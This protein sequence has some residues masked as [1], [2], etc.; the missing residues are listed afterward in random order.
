MWVLADHTSSCGAYFM[1]EFAYFIWFHKRVVNVGHAYQTEPINGRTSV[2]VHS[3]IWSNHPEPDMGRDQ[4]RAASL[5]INQTNKYKIMLLGCMWWCGGRRIGGCPFIIIITKNE[6][7][8]DSIESYN[9]HTLI[10]ENTHAQ[11]ILINYYYYYC[12]GR[13]RVCFVPSQVALICSTSGDDSPWS[14]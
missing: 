8:W 9:I 12:C 6:L 1:L 3:L 10:H 11:A 2:L 7:S 4:Q 13:G 14:T 5:L